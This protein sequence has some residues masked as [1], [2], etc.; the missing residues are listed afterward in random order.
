[1]QC[2][3]NGSVSLMLKAN[4]S[5]WDGSSQ[6]SCDTRIVWKQMS[7]KTHA[8]LFAVPQ[9]DKAFTRGSR[10]FIHLSLRVEECHLCGWGVLTVPCREASSPS[11]RTSLLPRGKE[12]CGIERLTQV[13]YR[14]PSYGSLLVNCFFLQWWLRF[15][16]Q[17]CRVF[18]DFVPFFQRKY[19]KE[20]F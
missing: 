8:F 20:F 1:M 5:L 3:N 4:S 14:P 2:E 7:K 19:S 17:L 16:S 9:C 15:A 12:C 13:H 11:H 18:H 10:W 6:Y